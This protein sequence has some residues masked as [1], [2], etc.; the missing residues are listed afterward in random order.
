MNQA[1]TRAHLDT[2]HSAGRLMEVYRPIR[3]TMESVRAL[4]RAEIANGGSELAQR[5]EHSGLAAGK[6][7]RPAMLLLSGACFGSL[8][9]THIAAAA[10]IELVHTATL[11]HDDVLDGADQRRHDASLNFRWDNTTSILTGDVLFARAFEV[12][13]Q[14]GNMEVVRRIANSSSRVCEGEI[15]QNAA[16]GN[17]EITE[18]DYLEM[19]SLK[20]AELC[21]CACGIGT[22][23][24][25]CDSETVQAFEA[26]G[27]DLGIA[28]QVI[29]DILDVTGCRERVG[30]TLG[31]DLLNR[32]ITLPIIHCLDQLDAGRKQRLVSQLSTGNID[33]DLLIGWLTEL[34]SISYARDVALKHATNALNFTAT[35]ACSPASKSLQQL[36]EFVIERTY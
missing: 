29:D 25:D 12:A 33:L 2:G 11:V 6:Q 14:T 7:I 10:A 30:K 35:L 34:G 16:A 19:I 5:L 8:G 26:Y 23:L 13:A 15:I 36:A 27:R 22:N 24:F 32:K 21:K 3:D 20:T 18:S 4:L 17:F 1:V 28:F 9:K 31:T